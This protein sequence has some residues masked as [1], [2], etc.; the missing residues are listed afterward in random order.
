MSKLTVQLFY[1][2][3]P[4]AV[5]FYMH[6]QTFKN[7]SNGHSGSTESSEEETREVTLDPSTFKILETDT[8]NSTASPSQVSNKT[9]NVLRF[10]G[11]FS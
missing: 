9:K 7:K 4:I 8:G 5:V 1:N 10:T 11:S 2:F 6:H 3:L